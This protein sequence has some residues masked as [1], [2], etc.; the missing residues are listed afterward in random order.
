MR[1]LLAGL[2]LLTGCV[3]PTDLA[4]LEHQRQADERCFM[5]CVVSD[6]GAPCGQRCVDAQLRRL[7]GG[8]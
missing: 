4:Q 8:D 2:V 1:T 3:A 7:R 6:G 5:W